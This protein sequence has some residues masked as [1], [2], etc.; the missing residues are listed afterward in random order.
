MPRAEAG[1]VTTDIPEAER[2]GLLRLLGPTLTAI[3]GHLDAKSGGPAR[4]ATLASETVEAL[5]DTG[6]AESCI[7]DALA[8]KLG[9]PVIDRQICAGAA[10]ANEHDV[11]LGWLDIPS[12]GR[13]Q[14]GRFMGVHLVKGGQQHSVLLGRSFLLD[15]VM[16]YDGPRGQ[17]AILW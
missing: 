8:K 6:A 16:I 17:V 1:P 2:P 7:D 9:L 5:V 11:Y 13:C 10:G 12:L 14:Y 4:D 15:V 3:V